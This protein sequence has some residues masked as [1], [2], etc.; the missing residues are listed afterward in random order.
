MSFGDDDLQIDRSRVRNIF[1]RR[2]RVS[3][4]QSSNTYTAATARSEYV[5][6]DQS[7]DGKT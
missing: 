4:V 3:G 2:Y 6:R 5:Y 7:V 1:Y